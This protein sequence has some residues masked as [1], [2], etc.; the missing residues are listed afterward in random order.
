MYYISIPNNIISV[1]IDFYYK[2]KK[3]SAIYT[4]LFIVVFVYIF[5]PDNKISYLFL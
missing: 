5:L 4:L 2:K 1:Q 3:N